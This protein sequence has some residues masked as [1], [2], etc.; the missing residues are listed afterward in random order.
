MYGIGIMRRTVCAPT[1]S[2]VFRHYSGSRQWTNRQGA[3]AD[4]LE[5][6]GSQHAFISPARI[7]QGAKGL[8]TGNDS[9]VVNPLTLGWSRV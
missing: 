5:S 7:E 9:P 1:P 3:V 4:H 6:P 2:R 8:K